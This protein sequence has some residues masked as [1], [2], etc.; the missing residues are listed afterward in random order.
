MHTPLSQAVRL[1]VARPVYHRVIRGRLIDGAAFES[2]I[3]GDI[4]TGK[5]LQNLTPHFEAVRLPIAR[6][7]CHRVTRGGLIDGA[8]FEGVVASVAVAKVLGSA[9][10]RAADVSHGGARGGVAPSNPAGVCDC[11]FSN[12]RTGLARSCNNR[13]GESDVRGGT[14]ER[15]QQASDLLCFDWQFALFSL[16]LLNFFLR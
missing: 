10:R 13:T 8:A 3:A 4:G 16:S 14:N 6:P 5:R 12:R 9:Q 11:E 2:M 15:K 7:V 1:S